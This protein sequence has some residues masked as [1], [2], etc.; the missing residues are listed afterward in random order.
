[1][2]KII[3]ALIFSTA[4]LSSTANTNKINMRAGLWE[5]TTTSDLLLLAQH[6]PTD[7]L[8][9]IAQIAKKYGFEMPQLKNGAA[10]SQA[11]ITQEMV[12]QHTLPN[13]YQ[14]E[15][16]CTSNNATR[17]GNR[18]QVNF[19]CSSAEL[20]GKGM[21]EGLITSVKSFSGTSTFKGVAQGASVN[22]TADIGGQ[23]V[24]ASCGSIAPL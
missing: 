13:F 8:N 2:Y 9:G 22:E 23:W 4:T 3:I 14:E 21:A 1:M 10:I 7:Q 6:I 12:D 5:I 24:S 20:K 19:S 16:G 17:N 11:C 15:L 18:Y